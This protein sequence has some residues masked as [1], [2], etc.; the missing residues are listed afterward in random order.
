MENDDV[1]HNL[2]ITE[3]DCVQIAR[4]LAKNNPENTLAIISAPRG[5]MLEAIDQGDGLSQLIMNSREEGEIQV[6]LTDHNAG[7]VT[8]FQK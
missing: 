4:S 3:D 7:K 1:K 8:K 5:S 2:F 6:Y